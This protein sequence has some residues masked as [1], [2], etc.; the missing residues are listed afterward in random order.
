[1]KKMKIF[2]LVLLVLSIVILSGCTA[3]QKTQDTQYNGTNQVK[4]LS[5]IPDNAKKLLGIDP[6]GN[7]TDGD[8]VDDLNDLTPTFADV[9]PQASTGVVGFRIQSIFVENNYDEVAKKDAPDHLELVLQST[10]N[11]DI[12]NLT[13]YYVITDAKINKKESYIK[14]LSGFVLKANETRTIHFDA[15]Q[16]PDHFRFNPNSIYYTTKDELNFTVIINADGYEA[17]T[18]QVKKDAGGA[19]AP[20]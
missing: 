8:G 7:D 12:Y 20:D 4:N 14:Q 13:V 11:K 1:M 3:P 18:I 15:G 9:P 17:Q 5:E 6:P 2:E 16:K 10:T 19:E